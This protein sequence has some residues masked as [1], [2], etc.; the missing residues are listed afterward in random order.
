MFKLLS[1]LFRGISKIERLVNLKVA[2]YAGLKI[3]SGTL[4][5][6]RQSFGSEPFL[7]EIGCNCLVTDGVKFITHDG[8]IQVPLILRGEKI[9]DV[10]SKKSTFSRIIV[11]DNVFL[12]VGSIILPGTNIG[13]NSIIAA[14]CV[15]KGDIPSGVVV[16]GNPGRVICEIEEYYRRNEENIIDIK[17]SV[18][19]VAQIKAAA[20]RL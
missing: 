14:G 19:R 6:G 2:K 20:T 9:A 18:N 5:V 15:V 3:G 1:F 16:G 8:S 11:G 17:D 10:Y 7:V 13:S 12:G 4:L